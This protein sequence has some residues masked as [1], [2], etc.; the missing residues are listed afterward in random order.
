MFQ[1]R[2]SRGLGW[3]EPA[4]YELGRIIGEALAEGLADGL[5]D[6][7]GRLKVDV[8]L[9]ARGLAGDLRAKADKDESDWQQQQE[10]LRQ[11]VVA[12][13]VPCVEDGCGERAVARGLC[14]KHYSS[15]LYFERKAR[16]IEAEGVPVDGRRRGRPAGTSRAASA[17]PVA[18]VAPIRRKKGQETQPEPAVSESHP[19]ANAGVSVEQVARFLGVDK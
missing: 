12:K 7:L 9:L 10:T 19:P 17:V 1:R 4:G 13:R 5:E 3:R 15:R 2:Q 18:P 14:R 11:A 16:R 8:E 6:A